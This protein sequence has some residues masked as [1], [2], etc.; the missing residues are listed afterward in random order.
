LEEWR[1]YIR[2]RALQK[3]PA[4]VRVML[5][6]SFYSQ[7]QISSLP[8]PLPIEQ[9]AE[10]VIV[11][12]KWSTSELLTNL[13]YYV[14]MNEDEFKEYSPILSRLAWE[15]A[16]EEGV[17]GNRD[18][19][20]FYFTLAKDVSRNY[21]SITINVARGYVQIGDRKKA[22]EEFEK[23]RDFIR[24]RNDFIPDVWLET[25]TLQTQLGHNM[26]AKN[27]MQDYF[28]RVKNRHKARSDALKWFKENN[29]PSEMQ[30]FL[31]S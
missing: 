17:S 11:K 16:L 12:N 3:A 27:T 22:L 2:L 26:K 29:A 31:E 9:S 10:T 25:A 30:T 6:K 1:A 24:R 23:A 19:A 13:R 18:R 21:V 15:A 28:A 8:I 14:L 5:S 7:L 4:F 20:E